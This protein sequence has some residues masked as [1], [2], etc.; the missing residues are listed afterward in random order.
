MSL[1]APVIDRLFERLHA[2]Y[3]KEFITKFES[4]DSSALKSS[5]GHELAGFA[6]SLH[7]IAWALEHL[8]IRCP[9]VIEFRMICRQ[10]PAPEAPALPAPPP[11]DPVRVKQ[12]LS[13]LAVLKDTPKIDNREWA[14]RILQR[15][16][17]GAYKS[18]PAALEMARD[19]L[20]ESA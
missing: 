8:P 5:W 16:E 17:S 10:A 6:K 3:G 14:R 20:K 1:S 19:A 15:H 12:E 18:T 9:N 11:A 7:C 2:T 13:K 4:V